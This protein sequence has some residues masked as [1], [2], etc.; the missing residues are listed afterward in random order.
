MTKKRTSSL[1]LP[2]GTESPQPPSTPASRKSSEGAS[3][4]LTLPGAESGSPGGD[5]LPSPSAAR[6]RSR[7]SSR[8]SSVPEGEA[9]IKISDEPSSTSQSVECEYEIKIDQMRRASGKK[10][11]PLQVNWTCLRKSLKFVF[12]EQNFKEISTRNFFG[13]LKVFR[14]SKIRN[15][16]TSTASK[17]E[18]GEGRN[19]K[20]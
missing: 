5:L 12:F 7:L 3:L 11:L 19:K 16:M 4:L 2:K 14:S 20:D 10:R 1:A 8:L 15:L 13:I 6:S 9:L 18:H 17:F